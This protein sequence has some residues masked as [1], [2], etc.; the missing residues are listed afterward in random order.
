MGQKT[1]VVAQ[2]FNVDARGILR[3][4]E[5]K[6]KKGAL[7]LWCACDTSGVACWDPAARNGG[8]PPKKSPLA[9]R[10]VL[11]TWGKLSWCG[12]HGRGSPGSVRGKAIQRGG[13]RGTAR[14]LPWVGVDRKVRGGS[15]EENWGV[16]PGEKEMGPPFETAGEQGVTVQPGER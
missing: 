12:S 1:M 3:H 4:E 9:T 6:K 16:G 15:S 8:S 14:E 7:S 13:I 11:G 5:L 10:N 2:T